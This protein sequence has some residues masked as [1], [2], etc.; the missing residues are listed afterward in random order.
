MTIARQPVSFA[1]ERWMRMPAIT[2]QIPTIPIPQRR[3]LLVFSGYADFTGGPDDASDIKGPLEGTGSAD[4]SDQEDWVEYLVE[5]VVVGP[6]WR[7]IDGVCPTV[8][9]G[10]HSQVSPDVADAMGFR[11]QGISNIDMVVLGP[12][13]SRI[14]LSVYVAVRGGLDGKILTLA[15]QVTAWGVLSIPMGNEGVF[16]LGSSDPT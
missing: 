16:F 14:R 1:V 11:V 9:I 6:H 13:A 4:T 15:Y 12:S 7:L 8:V 5:Q 3:D 10:G 2:V